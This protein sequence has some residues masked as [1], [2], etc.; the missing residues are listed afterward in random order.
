MWNAQYI[1]WVVSGQRKKNQPQQENLG[2]EEYVWYIPI[3]DLTWKTVIDILLLVSDQESHVNKWRSL[4][5]CYQ[6]DFIIDIGASVKIIY[7]E[8]WEELKRKQLK[9]YSEKC[10]KKLYPPNP[11]IAGGNSENDEHN[12]SCWMV[13]SAL[14]GK[15]KA[16]ALEVLKLWT[17]ALKLNANFSRISRII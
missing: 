4:L 2:K 16:S 7:K 6:V 11:W 1:S 13:G 12:F 15:D 10:G 17:N 3:P 5:R 9:C 8:Q 14:L